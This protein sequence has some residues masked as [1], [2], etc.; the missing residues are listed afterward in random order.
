VAQEAPA[1]DEQA[2]ADWEQERPTGIGA[3]SNENIAGQVTR[4][5]GIGD[6]ADNATHNTRT[7]ARPAKLLPVR[8]CWLE[9][10]RT[11]I[12]ERTEGLDAIRWRSFGSEPCEF[13]LA[14]ARERTKVARYA[15][16]AEVRKY[17]FELQVENVAWL[18]EVPSVGK[19]P[20]YRQ[21]DPPDDTEHP[22]SLEP[23]VLAVAHAQAGA[24]E[25]VSEHQA[26]EAVQLPIDHRLGVAPDPALAVKRCDVVDR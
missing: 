6:H 24:R 22:R 18:G 10:D 12:R 15:R 11:P 20:A 23:Q 14:L 2:T 1:L 17:F 3:L 5:E 9:L 19:F 13:F 7:T 25:H 21:E 26:L 4:A 8:D 16:A